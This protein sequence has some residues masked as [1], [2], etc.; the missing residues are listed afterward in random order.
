MAYLSLYQVNYEHSDYMCLDHML[1]FTRWH[2]FCSVY[3][4]ILLIKLLFLQLSCI[5]LEENM[6]TADAM[7]DAHLCY[8]SKTQKHI[9]LSRIFFLKVLDQLSLLFDLN[10]VNILR[11]IL[12]SFHS[13]S[14][15]IFFLLQV[16]LRS[17]LL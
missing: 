6:P 3:S 15:H 10:E 16:S 4:S 5:F 14:G 2:L 9:L 12:C 11:T 13:I 7:D 17:F 1:R 8:P